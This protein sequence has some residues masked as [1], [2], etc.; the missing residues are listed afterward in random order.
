[1]MM[2]ILWRPPCLDLPFYLHSELA[3]CAKLFLTMFSDW[4]K[5][6]IL[7]RSVFSHDM[8]PQSGSLFHLCRAHLFIY[9]SCLHRQSY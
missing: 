5:S 8:M 9:F 3:I 7:N 1:M 2:M 4:N 6:Q